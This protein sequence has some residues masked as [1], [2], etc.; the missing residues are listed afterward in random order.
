MN[1]LLL[2]CCFIFLASQSILSQDTSDERTSNNN[3]VNNS[4]YQYYLSDINNFLVN[5]DNGY[6]GPISVDGSYIYCRI[7][8]GRQS[9][10]PID[11]IDRVKVVTERRKIGIFCQS[12]NYI[13][14]TV[15]LAGQ[16]FKG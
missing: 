10:I 8:D 16:I 11:E 9:K 15:I 7:K 14:L 6:Y 13:S 1:K 3:P 2:L 5:F 12:G 4:N